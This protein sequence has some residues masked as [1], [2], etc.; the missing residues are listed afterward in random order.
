MQAPATP[1]GGGETGETGTQNTQKDLDPGHQFGAPGSTYGGFGAFEDAKP[2]RPKRS[3]KPWIIGAAV[4]V[5]LAGGS[6][7]AWLLGAFKGEVLAQ[8]SVQDGVQK[9]LREDFGEGDVKNV[10]CPKDQPVKSG[11]TFDCTLTVAG[12]PKKVT[13]RVLNDQAQYEVGA[14]K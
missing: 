8:Q 4:V 12:Q 5:V 6:V 11:T 10:S 9:I 14:P 7:A 1:A 2:K 3:K 13:V